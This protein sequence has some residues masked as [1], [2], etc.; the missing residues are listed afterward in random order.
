[1][2]VIDASLI[3]SAMVVDPNPTAK[4]NFHRRASIKVPKL[5]LSVSQR[6][7]EMIQFHG[8]T[9]ARSKVVKDRVY[10]ACRS[11][12]FD[13]KYCKARLTTSALAGGGY[14][15]DYNNIEHNHG[16]MDRRSENSLRIRNSSGGSG[17]AA[18]KAKTAN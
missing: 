4:A 8:F 5:D 10:W 2:S 1:M 13:G 12:N 18:R 11:R 3:L 6:G 7:Q 16:A 9:F 14:T 17:G 15:I